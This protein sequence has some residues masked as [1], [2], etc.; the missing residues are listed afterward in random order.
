MRV[1]LG[2]LNCIFQIEFVYKQTK[3]RFVFG[4]GRYRMS[5]FDVFVVFVGKRNT[6]PA[7]FTQ[8]R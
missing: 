4:V 7:I 6:Y 5:V 3:Y 8:K 2:T 1:R